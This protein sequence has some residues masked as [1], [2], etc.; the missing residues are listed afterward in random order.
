MAG[1]SVFGHSSGSRFAY[2]WSINKA[3]DILRSASALH[4]LLSSPDVARW[5][6]AFFILFMKF[7]FALSI[8]AHE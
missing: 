4:A 6:A 1:G 8:T 2:A 5:L 7:M 3:A